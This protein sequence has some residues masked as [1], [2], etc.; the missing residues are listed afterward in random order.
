MYLW[1]YKVNL[2]GNEMKTCQVTNYCLMSIFC[3]EKTR[4]A[5]IFVTLDCHSKVSRTGW[6]MKQQK[7]ISHNSDSWKLEI[8][9]LAQLSFGKNP[10]LGCGPQISHCTFTNQRA[11]RGNNLY[12]LIPNPIHKGFTPITL[13][14]LNCNLK[15]H[16]S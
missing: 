1:N 10:F 8:R 12:W 14:N 4:K 15:T 16:T 5:I 13:S 9:V 3:I 7:Y 11:E 6:L 2:L